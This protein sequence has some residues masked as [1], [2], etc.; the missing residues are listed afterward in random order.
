MIKI[1]KPY[2]TCKKYFISICLPGY[3]PEDSF[4]SLGPRTGSTVKIK[5][6]FQSKLPVAKLFKR[7]ILVIYMY[8]YNIHIYI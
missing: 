4:F 6:V 3:P 1:I 2:L 5:L 7:M 8:F